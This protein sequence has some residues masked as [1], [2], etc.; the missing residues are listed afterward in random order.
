LAILPVLISTSAPQAGAQEGT[1]VRKAA[2]E[3]FEFFVAQAG[4]RGG[5]AIE[6]ELV[7]L[8]GETVVRE[9]FEQVAKESGEEGVKSLVRL[10][11]S[12]GIDAILA[13]KVA[14]RLTATGMQRVAPELARGALRALTRPAERAVLE[15]IDS[16][17]VPGALEA[18]ARHPGV[19]A[20][21]VE[22]LGVAGVLASER[23][24]TDVLIELSRSGFPEKIAA[25]PLRERKS[26]LTTIAT[27]L[28]EHPKTVLTGTAL[29]VF[30]NYKDEFL[31]GKGEFVAGLD[32][33]PVW[34][35]KAGMIER[36]VKQ[37]L[38]YV[39][40]VFALIVGLWGLNRI[41]W[42]WR[43]SKLSHA[44]NAQSLARSRNNSE[45]A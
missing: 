16:A 32:G 18:A 24:D 19:G 2:Q 35:P 29:A 17:L 38:S 9:V 5:A 30:L 33:I 27:F 28:E 37:T 14:P 44:L 43:W 40:P 20:Q 36:V 4:K 12:Y 26:L 39:L 3:V 22:K 34:V 11:K 13:A 42:A 41:Y 1:L 45:S 10:S 23:C 21:V 31:G 7:E 6:K 25:L 8:G 15:R